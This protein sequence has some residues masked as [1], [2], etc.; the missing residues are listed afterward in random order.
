MYRR[1]KKAFTLVELIITV[2]IFSIIVGV[3]TLVFV[4]GVDVW[5]F[6]NDRAE[7]RTRANAAMEAM[8]QDL[9]EAH[10]V[11]GAT[12]T[13]ITFS[14]DPDNDGV[15]EIVTI[16]FNAAGNEIDRTFA[17]A[18]KILTPYVQSFSLSYCQAN[19]EVAFVPATQV[20]RDS[21]RV[22]NILLTMHKQN[23]TI[24]TSS[25]VLCRNQGT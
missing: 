16:A 22:V 9:S 5:S 2:A 23:E 17:G 11:T 18:L 25:S 10:L 24:T 3:A 13:S 12:A 6:G 1:T 19:T 8:V 4:T 20:D 14:A 7:I 15:D 21:M